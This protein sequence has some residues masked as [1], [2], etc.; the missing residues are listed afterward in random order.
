MLYTMKQ[1]LEV[2]N[3]ENF[4]IPAPNI[5]N[6]LT[7][8][9]VIEAAE[10]CNSPLIIDIAFPIHP[11]II[12]L[13]EMTRRLAEESRI[14]IAINLDHGGSRWLDLESCLREVMPCIRAGFTSIMVDRSRLSYDENVKQVKAA[15]QIAHALG[16]TV[17]AEL[18]HVG[19]GEQYDNKSDMVLTEPREARQFIEDTGVDCL[20]VSIGTAH[21]QYKGVPHLDFE[22]LEKIKKVTDN[23]PL[24]L[25]G[26]SGTGE[27]NLRKASKMGINKVNIGTDLFRAALHA[28]RTENLDGS[29]IYDIWQ[30]INDSWRDELI[31]W[32]ELLGASGK[33]AKYQMGTTIQKRK[34]NIYGKEEVGNEENGNKSG[35]KAN[36]EHGCRA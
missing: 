18:G 10:I 11:D 14:P 13:G 5:Q 3:E 32:I 8:R 28:V 16:V 25:H 35:V 12:F 29:R 34:I 19:D 27:E 6:E 4:A 7:A 23:F 9:A 20:A 21:G 30:V 24:V 22:R 26:G 17:E 15:V 31:K 33:A 2:A 36:G 1:L